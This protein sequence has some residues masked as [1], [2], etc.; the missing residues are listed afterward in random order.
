MNAV[1]NIRETSSS[2]KTISVVEVMGRN[3]GDI[4]LQ[5]GIASGADAILIP[6]V[7]ANLTE[8]ANSLVQ[9]FEKGKTHGIVMLAEGVGTADELASKLKKLTNIHTRAINLGFIQRGG[10]PTAFD[11]ILTTRLG[12]KVLELIEDDT[13]GVAIG[14]ENN[15]VTYHLI[16][17]VL[18]A[19]GKIND[20]LCRI[21]KSLA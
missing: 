20:T 4:A 16:S 9:G 1:M 15:Q 6:E 10:S 18:N 17:D 3:C 21:A 12:N 7:D 8:I 13:H 5:A 11:R 14:I 19:K 2:H